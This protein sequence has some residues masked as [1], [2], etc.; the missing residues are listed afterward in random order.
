MCACGERVRFDRDDGEGQCT[1]CGR[2]Y[3]K[4]DARVWPIR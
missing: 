4:E 2:V 3:G 1:G